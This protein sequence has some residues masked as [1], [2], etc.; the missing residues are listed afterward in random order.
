LSYPVVACLDRSDLEPLYRAQKQHKPGA[1]GDNAT[2][3][4]ILRHVFEIAPEVIKKP[5]E[6]LRALVHRHHQE[7]RVTALLDERCIHVLREGG[8]FEDWALEDIVPDREAFFGFLE[9]R[10]QVFIDKLAGVPASAKVKQE[11]RYCGPE[12]LPL[13]HSD[14][15]VYIDTFF[16]EGTLRPIAHRCSA[17][18]AKQW[19]MVGITTDPQADHQRRLEGL[20]ESIQGTVPALD[21]KHQEWLTFA[22]RFAE[23][24]ALWHQ[25]GKS[26]QK[27]LA[28][29][30]GKLQ[31]T[32]DPTF[33]AWLQARFAGLHNQPAVPPVMVHHVPHAMAR[34]V[35]NGGKVALVLMDGLAL[36]QWVVLRDILLQ[37]RPGMWPLV[38]PT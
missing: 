38:R 29:R 19:A 8:R 28:R 33:L 6:L 20:V 37:Q 17:T 2:K 1:L 25:V 23:L 32:V 13:D 10:W 26:G 7:Q 15:R 3:D 21:A 16:L 34:D 9:E 11:F 4:F 35:E 31:A 30:F 27:K 12:D 22:H 36:D 18:L 24:L 14:V 5:T